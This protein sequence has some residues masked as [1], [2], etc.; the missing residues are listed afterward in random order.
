MPA[1][2]TVKGLQ[3]A[4]VSETEEQNS[5]LVVGASFDKDKVESPGEIESSLIYIRECVGAW[6]QANN[7]IF[8][9]IFMEIDIADEAAQGEFDWIKPT[10]VAYAVTTP[11]G[12][13]E[14]LFGILAMTEGRSTHNLSAQIPAGAIP[15]DEG[16]NAAF[17]I[18]PE[19]VM[20]KLLAPRVHTLFAGAAVEDFSLSR[21]GREIFNC[22]D[23]YIPLHL[24]PEFSVFQNKE[25][26]GKL[27]PNSFSL[28]V[29]ESKINTHLRNISLNY[30]THDEIDLLLTYESE[31]VVGIDQ[32]GHF[33]LQTARSDAHAV[34]SVNTERMVSRAWMDILEMVLIQAATALL[35][36]GVGCLLAR[37][38]TAVKG[39][40]VVAA[41]AAGSKVV[42]EVEQ[43]AAAEIKAA[44]QSGEANAI[45]VAS[46]VEKPVWSA[47]KAG[48][49]T[50][51]YKVCNLLSG[52]FSSS[53][54]QMVVGQLFI[55]VWQKTSDRD[56]ASAYHED[57]RSMPNFVEFA[58]R[59]IS[60]CVWPNISRGKLEVVGLNSS[61]VMG[62]KIT[63]E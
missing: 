58:E 51:G 43:V 38:A 7:A 26:N 55:S 13:D 15:V 32:Y 46:P 63:K 47:F 3:G 39:S 56:L 24:E 60:P 18:S 14:P 11:V 34:P 6:L 2:A 62:M 35:M 9:Y 16:V 5:L 30:G 52:A 1:I 48:A 22:K 21:D 29:S 50:S 4:P 53:I 8:D 28:S 49:R 25:T 42:T 19:M 36:A 10:T 27:S 45:K 41:E 59:C 57:P 17:L 40:A 33:A 54:V 44:V 23:I 20:Q 37:V 61:L 12:K 31:N